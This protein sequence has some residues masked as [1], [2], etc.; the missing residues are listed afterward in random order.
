MD[1]L[2]FK[3]HEQSSSSRLLSLVTREEKKMFTM[4]WKY[5]FDY[6]THKFTCNKDL[7][8]TKKSFNQHLET[9][10]SNAEEWHFISL[11]KQYFNGSLWPIVIMQEQFHYSNKSLVTVWYC[12]SWRCNFLPLT[13][14]AWVFVQWAARVLILPTDE[15]DQRWIMLLLTSFTHYTIRWP[16][17]IRPHATLSTR[18]A[19]LQ[20]ITHNSLQHHL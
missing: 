4:Q 9:K 5:I 18:S 8:N 12:H 1:R 19:V 10:H 2:C 14:A 15:A 13:S 3:N 17:A 7:S 11:I 20:N 6:F 16:L